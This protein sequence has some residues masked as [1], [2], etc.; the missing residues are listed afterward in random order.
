M[1]EFSK[2]E[3]INDQYFISTVN[4]VDGEY[5]YSSVVYGYRNKAIMWAK[6]YKRARYK[7]AKEAEEGHKKLKQEFSC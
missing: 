3:V 6:Q 4:D 5:N 7:T 1:A 2:Q